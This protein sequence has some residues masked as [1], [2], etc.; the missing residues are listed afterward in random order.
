MSKRQLSHLERILVPPAE[1]MKTHQNFT[2][3]ETSPNCPHDVQGHSGHPYGHGNDLCGLLR[4]LVDSW[5][6]CFTMG[7]ACDS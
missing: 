3:N 5:Q 1:I 7:I 6:W 4:D 2:K